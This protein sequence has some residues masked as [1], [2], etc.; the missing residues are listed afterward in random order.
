MDRRQSTTSERTSLHSY[1]THSTSKVRKRTENDLELLK[2]ELAINDHLITL[3]DLCKRYK[4]DLIR[5][6]NEKVAAQLLEENGPNLLVPSAPKSRWLI[7]VENMFYG[8]S[9]LLWTGAVLS[10][11]GFLIHYFENPNS[12][13]YDHLYIALVLT[14]VVLITGFIGFYQEAVNNAIME[15]FSKMVPKFATVVRD[16]EK[17]VILA[18]EIVLGDLVIVALGDCVP[19][20]IRVIE[21]ES[22]KVDN[23]SLTGESEPQTRSSDCT[24]KNPMETQNLAFFGTSVVEGSGRGIVIACG[25]DT[26]MGH[27]AGLTS[28]NLIFVSQ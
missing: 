25:D 14:T 20:D 13:E 1:S 5:G 24:D 16:G 28:G 3:N 18:E 27:I 23:S 7:F 11:I 21:A 4:T 19:A 12:E 17:K 10:L 22:L 26:L 15:S 6:L 9:A 8:F 2:K